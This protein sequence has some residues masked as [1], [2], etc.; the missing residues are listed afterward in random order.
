MK[1]NDNGTG[2]KGKEK[3][4]LLSP[5]PFLLSK[6]FLL[7]AFCFLLSISVMA[8]ATNT[9]PADT[10]GDGKVDAADAEL[11][12]SYLLGTT[13]EEVTPNQVDVNGDGTV[14]TLDVVAV[15]VAM[16]TPEEPD[17]MEGSAPDSD[18][19]EFGAPAKAAGRGVW[20]DLWSE[21]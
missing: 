6:G 16:N 9:Q 11:I 20:G 8:A 14:N 3:A 17:G 21:E 10:T 4:S 13:D 7:S 5:F 1:S 12:Y 15:Y 18:D 19:S 2:M